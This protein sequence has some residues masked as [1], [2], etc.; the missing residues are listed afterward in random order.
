MIRDITE[1]SVLVGLD[2]ANKKH[3][4]CLQTS[5]KPSR[6]FNIIGSSP[7]AVDEWVQDLH[8]QYGGQIA[9][10]LE[11]D[12]GPIVYALQKYDYITLYPV[13]PLMLAK[14]RQV[15][16]P[17]GAKDDPT[18][19]ELALE[20]MIQ[21]PEKIKPLTVLSPEMRKLRHLVEQRRGLVNDRR[22][23][24][25]RLVNAL[26]QYYPQPLDWFSHRDTT[27]FCEFICRW[28]NLQQLKRAHQKTVRAFFKSIGG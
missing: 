4:V 22:R 8:Q 25:N 6:S 20:M 16:S 10:A 19:A 15:F 28:P 21:Y 27:M 26:K 7:E 9:I 24:T 3:D 11:L 17:S 18:D 13:H 23:L 5:G 1:Y 14:Y 2:W 12:K